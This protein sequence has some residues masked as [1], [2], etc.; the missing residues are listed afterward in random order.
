MA[1][2]SDFIQFRVKAAYYLILRIAHRYQSMR[3]MCLDFLIQN[4]GPVVRQLIFPYLHY[5]MFFPRR[6]S[7][8][9]SEMPQRRRGI[10]QKS[11]CCE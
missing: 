9:F 1:G 6:M 2:A 5:Y 10:R 4:I 8:F 3:D 11:S 7:G